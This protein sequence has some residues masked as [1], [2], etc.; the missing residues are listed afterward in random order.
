MKRE[1]GAALLLVLWLTMLIAGVVVVFAATAGTEALQGRFL[2]RQAAA[3][4][5]AEGGIEVAVLRMGSND[6][7]R[8][9]HPDGR[10]YAFALEGAQLEVRVVDESGKV[11]LNGASPELLAA[12]I[13]AVGGDAARAPAIAAAI[14]DFRDG[15]SLLSPGG[16]AEDGE[17]A[18]QDLPYGAKDRPFE[19][20][21]E[22]QQVLGMDG[23]L[24]RKLVPHVTIFTGLTRPEPNFASEPVLKALGVTAIELQAI[25]TRREPQ[26]NREAPVAELAAP[27][28]GTYS[29]SS[30]ATRP[31]GTKAEV[32]ATVRLGAGGGLGQ[33]YTPLAWRVG[34]PD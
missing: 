13:V 15:D 28:S 34:D 3:R 24:Y 1:R 18:A 4:Y 31:D 12:L 22:L 17:Y 14:Q 33:L 21:S 20:V 2:E 16:G 5:L 8:I 25:L 19:A 29:I 10:P 30:R 26:A 32:H 7:A 9:W 27:G 6:A 11:D 23:A